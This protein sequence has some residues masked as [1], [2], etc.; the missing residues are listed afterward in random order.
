MTDKSTGQE[1]KKPTNYVTLGFSLGLALGAG[2]GT[3]LS[4]ALDNP[5]FIAIGI[6]SGMTLGLAIGTSLQQRHEG[7]GAEGSELVVKGNGEQGTDE[8]GASLDG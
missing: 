6:G 5:A 8:D 2:W 1:S 4:A 7:E 3:A